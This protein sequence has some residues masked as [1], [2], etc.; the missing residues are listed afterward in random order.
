MSIENYNEELAGFKIRQGMTVKAVSPHA[1]KR[2]V[3]RNFSPSRIKRIL[4]DYNISYPGTSATGSIVYV[5]EDEYIVVG[6]DGT[7][8]SAVRR[9]E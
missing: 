5:L 1:F 3:S 7:I 8:I 4:T 2:A 9:G 6:H